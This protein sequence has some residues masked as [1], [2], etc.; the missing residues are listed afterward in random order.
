[1]NSCINERAGIRDLNARA[2]SKRAATPSCVH[3]PHF[4]FA[5][6]YFFSKQLGIAGW[7]QRKKCLAEAGRKCSLRLGNSNFSSRNFCS[8]AG[9]EMIHGL[10]RIELRNR[11]QHSESICCKEEN[12]F[13]FGAHRG[14]NGIINKINRICYAGVFRFL[15]I[16]EINSCSAGEKFG[17]LYQRSETDSVKNL[18]FFFFGKIYAFSITSSFKIKYTIVTPAMLIITN[19]FAVRVSRKRCLSCT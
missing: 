1:M 2:L 13:W 14:F 10:S 7:M 8:V 15:D 16:V 4:H 18:W 5:G 12:I 11:R 3:Q 6:F 9:N 17:V 19:Q